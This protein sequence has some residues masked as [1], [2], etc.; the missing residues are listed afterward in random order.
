MIRCMVSGETIGALAALAWVVIAGRAGMPTWIW[1]VSV[2]AVGTLSLTAFV[3][4]S[5]PVNLRPAAAR[6]LARNPRYWA[7]V[8][9]ELL[10]MVIVQ[11]LLVA[12]GHPD[13][14]LSVVL[15]AV[16][17]HFLPLMWALYDRWDAMFAWIAVGLTGCGVGLAVA[18][19]TV[20]PQWLDGLV[21][22]VL[23]ALVLTVI[24]LVFGSLG[25]RRG[26]TVETSNEPDAR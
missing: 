19:L 12:R 26:V 10:L 7:A 15:V 24:P 18:R 4:R 2:A 8:A 5:R 16:G 11:R 21:G 1:A 23:P 9:F 3:R 17:V 6:G 13:L 22:G 14:G 20:G 25:E